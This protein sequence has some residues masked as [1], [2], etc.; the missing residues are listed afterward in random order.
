MLDSMDE[1]STAVGR[2]G[3]QLQ[4]TTVTLLQMFRFKGTMVMYD[5]PVKKKLPECEQI[6]PV[7]GLV[8]GKPSSRQAPVQ[9]SAIPAY[10]SAGG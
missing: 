9:Q 4:N 8:H 1:A 3:R 2:A 7:I 6:W 5:D 10:S